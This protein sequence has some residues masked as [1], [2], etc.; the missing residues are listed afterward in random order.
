MKT[1]REP[2]WHASRCGY[3][4]Q[5]R[6]ILDFA[7]HDLVLNSKLPKRFIERV[8]EAFEIKDSKGEFVGIVF[9]APTTRF[10]PDGGT[11]ERIRNRFDWHAI[12]ARHKRI[13]DW[14][15]HWGGKNIAVAALLFDEQKYWER[16]R[17]KHTATSAADLAAI[18]AAFS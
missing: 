17:R 5:S 6:R 12:N 4:Y 2:Q 9:K 10:P 7:G 15:P 16:Q 11:H 8:L 13:K 14:R 18:A 1:I 3:H